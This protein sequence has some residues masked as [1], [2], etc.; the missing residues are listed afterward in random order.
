M[1]RCVVRL[2]DREIVDVDVPGIDHPKVFEYETARDGR[3]GYQRFIRGRVANVTFVVAGASSEPGW[4]WNEL[5]TIAQLQSKRIR[6]Q[7]EQGV[8]D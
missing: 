7:L 5:V 8:G 6:S 3:R 2:A 4:P 1:A